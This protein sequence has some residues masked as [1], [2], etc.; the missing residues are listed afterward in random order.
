MKYFTPPT[1]I[2]PPGGEMVS[3]GEIWFRGRLYFMTGL[4][5]CEYVCMLRNVL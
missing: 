4:Y 2:S 1:E 3:P 5:G